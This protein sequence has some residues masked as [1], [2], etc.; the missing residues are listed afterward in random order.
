VV[1]ICIGAGLHGVYF[2]AWVADSGWD[3]IALC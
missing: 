2:I 1:N 3:G